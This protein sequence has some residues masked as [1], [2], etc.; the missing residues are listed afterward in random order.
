MERRKKEEE[1][2]K[3]EE[4][5]RRKTEEERRKKGEKMRKREQDAA[6]ELLKKS[7][8]NC[9]VC[10]DSPASHVGVPCGHQSVCATCS[11]RV[12][13]CPVCRTPVE[14]I[15]VFAAG[16]QTE[17]KREDTAELQQAVG[18][19]KIEVA[20][21]SALP[22]DAPTGHASYEKVKY[23]GKVKNPFA[24]FQF[25]QL[26]FQTTLAAAGSQE[27]CLVIA[28]AC[29]LQF[30]QGRS[31]EEVTKF[32]NSCYSH[33]TGRA[34]KRQAIDIISDDDM[35]IAAVIGSSSSA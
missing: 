3:T 15:K 5:E 12:P 28:R 8:G 26:S 23:N 16:I 7:A 32:R 22:T 2:R 17:A 1:R 25:G 9:I 20:I 27:A 29:Y 30:E 19:R 33:A 13:N 24:R 21:P 34:K 14:F 6:E 18:K 31:K 35:P 10:W 4:E 11:S